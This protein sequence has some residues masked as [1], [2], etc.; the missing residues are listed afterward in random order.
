MTP[1]RHYLTLEALEPI[2]HG[3][4][5]TGTDNATNTRLFMRSGMLLEGVAVRVPDVSENA[6]RSV[7]VRQPIHDHLLRT[8]GLAKGEI[9][10]PVMNLLYSGGN[11]AAGSTAPT[12]EL[13]LG[14]AVKALYPS[15]DLL[16]GA[17]DSFILP[18][19]RLRVTA[20][21]LAREY[22]WA[23]AHV[24]PPLAKRARDASIFELLVEETRT[25]G[26]GS[27]SAGNQTLYS[28]ETLAAG[29]RI[30]VEFTLD[31]WTPE[32]AEAALA[33]AI[34]SWDGFFGGHGRQGRGRMAILESTLGDGAAYLTH[35][36]EHAAT[37]AD[38]L[39]DG[40]LG[41]GKVLCAR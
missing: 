29:T 4:T 12:D 18:R 26:T 15:L 14:H 11:M 23:L 7:L 8:L 21:P 34:A 41:T 30:L 38:G 13:R 3:D 35:L 9:P 20:W 37:L 19:S 39:R 33:T 2:A 22:A 36:T 24:A 25:R 31:A 40:T 16:G 10:Q 32:P 5:L 17:V 28:Y 1:R 27:D 6:I